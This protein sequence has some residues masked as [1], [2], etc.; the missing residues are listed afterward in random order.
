[1][2]YSIDYGDLNNE[3]QEF[4]NKTV[5]VFLAL[6]D[7]DISLKRESMTETRVVK[8]ADYEKK[9][10]SLLIAGF[11]VEGNL[12]DLLSQFDIIELDNLLDCC[13][14][15]IDEI[16]T[17]DINYEE[18]YDKQFKFFIFNNLKQVE[19]YNDIERITPSLLLYA[20]TYK[21]NNS[22]DNFIYTYDKGHKYSSYFYHPLKSSLK[23]MLTF[24]G[25]FKGEDSNNSKSKFIR[26]SDIWGSNLSSLF[27]IPDI[28]HNEK[29]EDD[30]IEDQKEKSFQVDDDL[31]K[32]VD[33][34]KQK[35]IGQEDFCEK[36]FNNI[37]T[38]QVLI[39]QKDIPNS[40]K[41]LI[42]VDGSS[43][44]GKTAITRDITDKLNIPF[45]YTDITEYSATGYVGGDLTNLLVDL[46]KNAN[47]DLEKAQ[48]GIIVI[49]E[50][51]KIS[52]LNGGLQMKNA[53]QHQLLNFLGGGIYDISVGKGFL[54]VKV[55]FDTS[56]ITFICLGALTDLRLKKTM[57]KNTIGF[58][59][60]SP[61][62]NDI[63]YSI[64]P[65][66]L[67][68]IGLQK[69]LVGRFN[70]YLHT[71]DYDKAALKRILIESVTSPMI[72]FRKLVETFNKELIIQDEV[73][74]LIAE[75]A[76]ALNTGARSLE[77]VMN[78]IRTQYLN[79]ILRGKENTIYL[80]T[81]AV[82]FANTEAMTRKE[83]K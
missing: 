16:K 51:E 78:G 69:E 32:T 18:L 60:T 28:S 80:D 4:I 54:P 48:R 36:L 62:T 74:D 15:K 34:L 72:G 14:L 46:Y 9:L 3:T 42:F 63:S 37:V 81:E 68:G 35:F 43:G 21:N 31:W 57:K 41:S 29:K 77:T 70:T 1:M 76:H 40:Q 27:S 10:F 23:N 33:V 7:K 17:L 20:A 58:N 22:L 44:T 25:T 5:E 71:E 11:L 66:D 38:N 12:K 82:N 39:D 30:V 8:L 6:K 59:D 61:D 55:K 64:T 45:T 56:K 65:Q 2:S 83:R 67:I 75:Q 24:E 26:S 50:I 47:G 49:D 13:G 19:E 79:E 53:V 73:Y 52:F